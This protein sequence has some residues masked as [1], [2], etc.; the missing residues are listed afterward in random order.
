MS[1]ITIRKV[2]TKEEITLENERIDFSIGEG[3]YTFHSSVLCEIFN[4]GV[5]IVLP[6][7]WDFTK[8]NYPMKTHP[9]P[10]V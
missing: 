9:E 1:K 10:S 7:P 2:S 4:A 3:T 5:D 8:T 6:Q